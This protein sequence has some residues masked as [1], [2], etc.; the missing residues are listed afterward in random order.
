MKRSRALRFYYLYILCYNKNMGSKRCLFR[1]RLD[2]DLV[3]KSNRR[4]SSKQYLVSYPDSAAREIRMKISDA[5]LTAAEAGNEKEQRH[6]CTRYRKIL[7]L[8]IPIWWEKLRP[9]IRL[10]PNQYTATPK[11]TKQPE[12]HKCTCEREPEECSSCEQGYHSGCRYNCKYGQ[13][14]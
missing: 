12:I 2:G 4:A 3:A 13:P 5:Q 11:P 8:D 7:K 9:N 6:I 1:S 10:D 14:R